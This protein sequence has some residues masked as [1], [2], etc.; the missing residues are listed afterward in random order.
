MNGNEQ[1]LDSSSH[2]PRFRE[3]A[4]QRVIHFR[5]LTWIAENDHTKRRNNDTLTNLANQ[6]IYLHRNLKNIQQRR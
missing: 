2:A 1:G 3:K 6:S 5:F 4:A